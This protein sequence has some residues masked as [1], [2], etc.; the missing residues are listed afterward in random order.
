M[1]A[2]KKQNLL[3]YLGYYD[4]RVDGIWGAV[5]E[6]AEAAFRND[7]GNPKSDAELEE[8]L[9]GAVFHSKFKGA[10][11]DVAGTAPAAPT[12]SGAY[13]PKYFRKEEFACKCGKYCNGFP[14]APDE[15]LLRVM[16][17]IREEVGLPIYVTSFIRCR[18]HNINEGGASNSRHLYG[19]A[20]D[21]RC[22]GK[23]PRQLYDIACDVV[24]N[25][26]GVG[27]YSWGIHVD[28]GKYTRWNG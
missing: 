2:T 28:T 3:Q 22:P 27:I 26:G 25:S 14:V 23:T 21:I 9:L 17:E 19:D 11:G 7:N 4:G 1:T 16:D 20:A 8:V 10:Q 12:V 15:E 13:V 5:S 6:A 18:Q 24:G